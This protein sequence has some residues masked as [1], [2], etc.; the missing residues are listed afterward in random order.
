MNQ[1]LLLSSSPRPAQ[2]KPKN[3]QLGL[4]ALAND[5]ALDETVGV[6]LRSVD[7]SI[8]ARVL[9]TLVPAQIYQSH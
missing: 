8:L 7:F 5:G 2:S 6:G 4:S 3:L 9:E 1:T